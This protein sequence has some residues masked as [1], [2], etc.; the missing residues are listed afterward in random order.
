MMSRIDVTI[1]GNGPTAFGKEFSLKGVTEVGFPGTRLSYKRDQLG[2]RM[3][4]SLREF[5][6][7]DSLVKNALTSC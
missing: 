3:R 2:R 4:L 7:S 6:G 1:E 5:L